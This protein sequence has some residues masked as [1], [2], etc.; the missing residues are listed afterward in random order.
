MNHALLD[1]LSGDYKNSEF[2]SIRTHLN[3][4]LNARAGSLVHL[5]DYGLPDVSSIYQSLPY[6]VNDLVAA[7][8]ELI[9]KYEPRLQDVTITPKQ[10]NSKECVLQLEISGVTKIAGVSAP[11]CFATYFVSDGTAEIR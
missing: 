11:L 2:C 7:I 1:I 6:S 5:P 8:K 4:L 10:K 3:R 9:E